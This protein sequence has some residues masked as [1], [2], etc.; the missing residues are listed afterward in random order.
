METSYDIANQYINEAREKA[1]QGNVKVNA[2]KHGNMPVWIGAGKADIDT[3]LDKLAQAR[4]VLRSLESE[5]KAARDGQLA[6]TGSRYISYL[7]G[8]EY[9][10]GDDIA[11][12]VHAI[13]QSPDR[14]HDRRP[15]IEIYDTWLRARIDPSRHLPAHWNTSTPSTGTFARD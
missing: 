13:V 7:E 2:G 5:I 14:P 15:R 4:A 3:A 9:S 11:A 12:L 10:R 6:G 1:A 8:A